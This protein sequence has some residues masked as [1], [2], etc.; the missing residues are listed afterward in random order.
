M[1]QFLLELK[2]LPR[3]Q[4]ILLGAVIAFLG[5]VLYAYREVIQVLLAA[6]LGRREW[7]LLVCVPGAAA[8][9]GD[10]LDA[11]RAVAAP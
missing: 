4:P 8:C 2:K 5:M 9:A 11:S 1:D 3:P 7:L 6:A 10:D